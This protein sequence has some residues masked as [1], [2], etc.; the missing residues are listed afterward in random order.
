MT[1]VAVPCRPVTCPERGPT[2]YGTI[3]PVRHIAPASHAW[4][5]SD[6]HLAGADTGTNEADGGGSRTGRVRDAAQARDRTR[7]QILPRHSSSRV[8]ASAVPGLPRASR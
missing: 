3:R 5:C 7:T 4:C 1:G 2:A 6:P 8:I